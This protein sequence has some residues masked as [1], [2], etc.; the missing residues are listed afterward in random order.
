MEIKGDPLKS[1][2]A[3]ELVMKGI[4]RLISLNL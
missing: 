4:I 2:R 1:I 3:L